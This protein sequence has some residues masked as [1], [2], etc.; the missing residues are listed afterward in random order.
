MT[1]KC[2]IMRFFFMNSY[3]IFLKSEHKVDSSFITMIFSSSTPYVKKIKNLYYGLYNIFDYQR[4]HVGYTYKFWTMWTWIIFFISHFLNLMKT[5]HH[6]HHL[7]VLKL[8]VHKI[9]KLNLSLGLKLQNVKL[10]DIS[11]KHYFHVKRTHW[12][13]I[14]LKLVVMG[15]QVVTLMGKHLET[16]KDLYIVDRN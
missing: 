16:L 12:T 1:L 4:N 8:R 5:I 10:Y 2:L 11:E 13:H 6:I 7:I 14:E 15:K 3:L 9:L